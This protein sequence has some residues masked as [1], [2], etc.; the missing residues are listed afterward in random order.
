[1]RFS[2]M[3]E[4]QL[5]GTYDQ[6]LDLARWAEAEGMVSF[7]RSDHFYSNRQPTPDAT[8]AF[9]TLA[10][11]ARDTESI[12]LCVLV[13]PITFRHPAVI[14]K[15]AATIDQMS[16]GRLDLGVGTG[17]MD[18]EHDVYGLPFPPWAERFERLSEALPYLRAAF[19]RG[20]ST[21]EGSHYRLD[22]SVTPKPTGVRLVVGGSGPKRTPTLAGI[23][24]DEYNHLSTRP[25]K[26]APKIE[27][28]RRSAEEAGRDPDQ[29]EITMMGP[30]VTGRDEADFRRRLTRAA[31]DR[32]L[33]PDA[34]LDRWTQAGVPVGPPDVVSEA[35]A[36]LEAVGVSRYY[37]QWLDL[38][39]RD[40]L[41]VTW[42]ALQA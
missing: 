21:F 29:I 42:G 14:A 4:P 31:A 3:T 11:L 6:L 30:V 35:M 39:D 19:S 27:V 24:A 36:K 25:E 9:A 12:R 10:G 32:D 33:D 40:G 7:S 18:L 13:S 23:H 5:G 20:H 22:A 37:I 16:G 2:L 38:D 28:L 41:E 15:S 17:W 34:L 1:M 8:D 26:L